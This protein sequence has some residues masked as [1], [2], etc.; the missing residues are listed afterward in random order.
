MRSSAPEQAGEEQ[1]ADIRKSEETP[2]GKD[3]VEFKKA[4]PPTRKRLRQLESDESGDEDEAPAKKATIPHRFSHPA[5]P[6]P[7]LAGS[8]SFQAFLVAG[9]LHAHIDPQLQLAD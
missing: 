8:Q 3:K 9:S 7:N 1:A 4:T 2:P 5:P 6:A